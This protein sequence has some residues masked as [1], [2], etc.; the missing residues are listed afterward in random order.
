MA[1]KEIYISVDVEAN[2]PLPGVHSM[3]SL[4]AVALM[5]DGSTLGEFTRNLEELPDG[6]EHPAT[7]AWWATQSPEVWEA[8]RTDLVSP[9]CAMTEFVAWVKSFAGYPVFVAMPAGYDWAFVYWYMMRFVGETPFGWNVIDMR[10][11]MMAM[12]KTDYSKTNKQ[13]MPKRWFNPAM[14][15]THI[16]LDDAREQAHIFI[17]MLQENLSTDGS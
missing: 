13:Y 1:L 15:H 11:Y 9:E 4:G 12:R 16:A 6:T 17:N 14:P 5:R 3:L 10:T 7:V 8:H 2:G